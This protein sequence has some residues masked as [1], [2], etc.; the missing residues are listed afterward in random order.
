MLG[1]FLD[2]LFG[3]AIDYIQWYDARKREVE[4]TC[5]DCEMPESECYCSEK[6]ARDRQLQD[7]FDVGYERAM[8]EARW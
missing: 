2:W 1:V 3:K 5:P 4:P 8:E 7:A 6:A